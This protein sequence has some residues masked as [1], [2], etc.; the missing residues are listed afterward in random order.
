MIY[1]CY[2]GVGKSTR[3]HQ[4]LFRVHGEDLISDI[5]IDLESSNFFVDGERPDNWYKIYCNIARDLSKQGYAVFI[6]SHK[7][8]REWMNACGIPFVSVSPA[9]ELKDVWLKK[10]EERYSL[11]PTDKNSKALAQA[12]LYYE[13]DVI[14]M[15]REKYPLVLNGEQYALNELISLTYE[16]HDWLKSNCMEELIPHMSHTNK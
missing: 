14:D 10:L 5:K 2:Q 15:Q 12:R 9:V 1:S 4:K 11:D 8:V 7:Q 3:Y 13:R 6:S 16:D